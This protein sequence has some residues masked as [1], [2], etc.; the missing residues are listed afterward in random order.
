MRRALQFVIVLA[1][2]VAVLGLIRHLLWPPSPAPAPE[3]QPVQTPAPLAQPTEPPAPIPAQS[4]VQIVV[5]PELTA[6]APQPGG[7]AST[8]FI[9]PPPVE[10]IQWEQQIDDILLSQAESGDKGRRLLALFPQ[11]PPEAQVEAAP[12]LAN[13]TEDADFPGLGPLLTNASTPQ[14]VLEVLVGDL[15]NRPNRIKLPLL[16]AI[17]SVP[18]HPSAAEAR[19][20]LETMLGQDHGQDWAAWEA[21]IQAWLKEHEE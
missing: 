9:P 3:T 14:A 17:A 7:P 13:L 11:L 12:H 16:L 2:L 8:N 21:A 20:I 6:P 15:L 5:P 18:D 1:L 19:T 10:R 4:N